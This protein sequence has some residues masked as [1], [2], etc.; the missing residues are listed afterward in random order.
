MEW[1]FQKNEKRLLTCIRIT[2]LLNWFKTVVPFLL[3]QFLAIIS[4][5]SFASVFH[6]DVYTPHLIQTDVKQKQLSN[7]N[8]R[9]TLCYNTKDYPWVVTWVL[10]LFS[11]KI[12]GSLKTLV[13]TV[14]RSIFMDVQVFFDA[15][16]QLIFHNIIT[17]RENENGFSFSSGK[18]SLVQFAGEKTLY[19]NKSFHF[20]FRMK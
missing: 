17:H 19:G 13:T 1:G 5:D 20:W 3:I 4:A 15:F 14:H 11:L 12:N 7:L 9:R 10:T 8:I 6:S 2:R 18:T 16:L